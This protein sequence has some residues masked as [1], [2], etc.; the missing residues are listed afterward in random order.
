MENHS[1][2][3]FL[4]YPIQSTVVCASSGRWLPFSSGWCNAWCPLHASAEGVGRPNRECLQHIRSVC[5]PV[6]GNAGKGSVVGKYFNDACGKIGASWP[7][8]YPQYPRVLMT[9]KPFIFL[10][11]KHRSYLLKKKGLV[12]H[13]CWKEKDIKPIWV[14][15]TFSTLLK[16]DHST[17]MLQQWAELCI[18]QA[19]FKMLNF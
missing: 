9:D 12:L 17:R 19:N 8:I 18:L 1:Y 13:R 6:V 4:L 7:F 11:L 15:T 10:E 14:I 5:E 3:L 2:S 16:I